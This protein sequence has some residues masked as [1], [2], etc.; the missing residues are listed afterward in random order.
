METSARAR[1][2]GHHC[3]G[4]WVYSGDAEENYGEQCAFA[5][6]DVF[7]DDIEDQ[8]GFDTVVSVLGTIDRRDGSSLTSEPLAQGES[9]LER[10]NSGRFTVLEQLLW[11][12]S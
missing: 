12:N 10:A 5:G 1:W 3:A 11:A 8:D 2:V 4:S 6:D 7:V 9:L